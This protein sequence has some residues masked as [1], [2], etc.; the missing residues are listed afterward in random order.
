ME[1]Q[2]VLIVSAKNPLFLEAYFGGDNVSDE[3]GQNGYRRP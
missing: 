3:C 2:R 1:G